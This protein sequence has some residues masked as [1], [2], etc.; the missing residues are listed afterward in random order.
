MNYKRNH[1]RYTATFADQRSILWRS[2]PSVCWRRQVWS[3]L[4]SFTATAIVPACWPHRCWLLWRRCLCPG[5]QTLGWMAFSFTLVEGMGYSW[6]TA[7]TA[8]FIRRSPVFIPLPFN[9]RE[10]MIEQYSCQSK[11]CDHCRE[12][13]VHRLWGLKNTESLCLVRPLSW[14]WKLHA[15]G[16]FGILSVL[17]GGVFCFKNI[18]GGIFFKYHLY[19]HQHSHGWQKSLS[20]FFLSSFLP[21]MEPSSANSA[22]ANFLSID[23]DH[24]GFT[25]FLL[26]NIFDTVGTLLGLAS[27]IGIVKSDGTIPRVKQAMMSD[28]IQN[29]YW[30]GSPA[31]P[32][33]RLM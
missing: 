28:A 2:D 3:Q 14:R 31:P 7:L 26:V 19:R 10:M 21:N 27:K 20:S 25:L 33:L 16:D 6:Q 4:R 24:C 30:H 29:D 13:N 9:I 23:Y 5:S 18:K 15:D 1:R 8:M 32:R 17:L 22:S 11:I 12:S